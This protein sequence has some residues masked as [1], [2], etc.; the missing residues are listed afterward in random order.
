MAVQSIIAGVLIASGVYLV[1]T[2][3]L[4]PTV[5][6]YANID[7]YVPVVS[8][9]A[10]A[11]KSNLSAIN[12]YQD[13]YFE[14]KELD[15]GFRQYEYVEKGGVAYPKKDAERKSSQETDQKY[16]YLTIPKLDITKA[17]VE[18]NSTNLDPK[19]S[20]GH[21]D[22]TC[23][24]GEGCNTFIYG[25]SSISG[26][27][28]R[29]EDNNYTRIFTKLGDLKYGEEFYIEYD[30]D[31]D[32]ELEEY[33]YIVDLTRVRSP[34]DVNPLADPYPGSMGVHENTVELFTCTPPGTTL[35]RLSVVGKLVN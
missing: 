13:T 34:E 9:I 27:N 10:E 20:L 12:T 2:K 33:R 23:L 35:Y 15:P 8:P 21:Y 28:S 14:F 26:L 4:V 24:P 7:N 16:F 1:T 19:E 22:N 30:K 11:P 29:H 3:V 25:H 17:K 18:I 32:G 6:I 5:K 31:G